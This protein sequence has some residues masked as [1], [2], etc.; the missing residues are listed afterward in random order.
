MQGTGLQECLPE[1][2]GGGWWG[3][4]VD[5]SPGVPARGPRSGAP[6]QGAGPGGRPGGPVRAGPGDPDRGAVPGGWSGG[7]VRATGPGD[8]SGGPVHAG[9]GGGEGARAALYPR[10]YVNRIRNGRWCDDDV[11]RRMLRVGRECSAVN[12]FIN[13]V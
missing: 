6:V 1:T 4:S 8:R 11:D 3:Q 13:F 7:P 12:M 2:S 5:A 9:R 10:R